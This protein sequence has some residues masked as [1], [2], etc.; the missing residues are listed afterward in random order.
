MYKEYSNI[1]KDI[2]KKTA[3]YRSISVNTAL[4]VWG[5][6][7]FTLMIF[8]GGT[9][10]FQR[11]I[12]EDRM[13]S[14]ANDIAGSIGQ[15][16]ATAIINN[17]YGFTVEHC[18]KIIKQSNSIVYI[19]ITR[20]DGFSL[21]HIA[22]KWHMDNLK[23]ENSPSTG[24]IAGGK[25]V[26]SRLANQEVFD[27][28]YP[29]SYSGI[30]WGKIT[31]GLSLKKYNQSI[32]ELYSRTF[33]LALL[34]VIVGLIA[35]IYFTRLLSKPIIELDKV[36]QKVAGGDLSARVNI[37]SKNEL[38]RLADSFNR[39]TESLKNSQEILEGKVKERTA[40]LQNS[41]SEKE[42]LLKEIHHRVKNNLQV[43][44]SL[45][46][47]GSKKIKDQDTLD[48]FKDS[49]NRVKSIAL[50]HERLYQSKDLEKIDFN[51]YI[52]KLTED[53]YR[54][55]GIDKSEV[56]LFTN[57]N[58]LA[59]SI[60]SGVPC[61]LIINELISNS[62]KYAFPDR[63]DKECV[64]EIDFSYLKDGRLQL[65]ISDNGIGLPEGIDIMKT[66]SLGLQLVETLVAQLDGTL[67]I[68]RTSGTAFIIRFKE[69]SVK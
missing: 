54:S 59:I 44:S 29:F 63:T 42:V 49:Q 11:Q 10:P 43:I 22:D 26:Y 24:R 51:Q 18:L 47:L 7:I 21:V 58:D 56:R 61:G 13:K 23:P 38:G 52:I 53:L 34:S 57:I 35:S 1:E 15:V 62:F 6:I 40:E 28:T 5:L 25:F 69:N 50:V 17:D 60:D 65:I 64:I 8:I 9:I 41:L 45:L 36:S 31:V 12:L 55:Y 68:D 32:S 20:N 48:M 46:Y 4:L 19:I 67:E 37:S 33:L 27:Y 16:T 3:W 14:E 30:E 39:M 2:P 66:G